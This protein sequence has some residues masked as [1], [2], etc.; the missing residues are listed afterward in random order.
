MMKIG[1]FYCS[2]TGCT[3]YTAEQFSEEF[4]KLGHTVHCER[5]E[6]RNP[7]EPAGYDMLGFG[8]PCYAF[9]PPKHFQR[10]LRSLPR[11]NTPFFLF[12]SSHGISGNTLW[13]MYRI[14]SR[15]GYHYLGSPFEV[16]GVLNIR[17]W[18][19]KKNSPAIQEK[20]HGLEKLPGCVQGLI[21]C[22]QD[23][24]SGRKVFQEK[25]T[26]LWILFAS[27]CTYPWLMA[28]VEGFFKRVDYSKCT[29]CGLCA[30]V[31]CPSGAITLD[32]DRKPVIK[33]RLCEG[34]SGCVNLCPEGAVSTLLN[35]NR[36]ACTVYGKS[37]INRGRK[38]G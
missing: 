4:R 26:I 27:W 38:S 33:N 1:I 37:I 18:R 32:Q 15:R 16:F 29:K 14:L 20:L 6:R 7:Q 2:G 36:Q 30:E 28:W 5:F 17:A 35:R 11:G 23:V 9:Y 8:A 3:A 12:A 24:A 31:I 19:R 13:S 25:G 22:Y 21:D 10:F 34:C